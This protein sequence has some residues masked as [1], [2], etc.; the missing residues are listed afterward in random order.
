ML[1][2][3]VNTN[4]NDDD[5]DNKYD[6]CPPTNLTGVL[7]EIDLSSIA[8]DEEEEEANNNFDNMDDMENSPIF[9]GPN[10]NDGEEQPNDNLDDSDVGIVNIYGENLG[11]LPDSHSDIET[12]RMM[13]AV[14]QLNQ[15]ITDLDLGD[16]D[17]DDSMDVTTED[18]DNEPVHKGKYVMSGSY[19]YLP[20]FVIENIAYA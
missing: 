8:A 9:G 5:D 3:N 17:E 7:N 19:H 4:D 20:D 14:E 13:G 11:N 16:D 1:N 10:N 18:D 12:K 2:M 15:S 6:S